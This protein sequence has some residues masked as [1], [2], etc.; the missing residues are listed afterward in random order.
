MKQSRI[1]ILLVTLCLMVMSAQAHAE[2][3]NKVFKDCV[4]C[5]DLVVIP[6]GSFDMRW[7]SNANPGHRV[8]IAKSFAIGQTEVR[9]EQWFAVMGTQP[10]NRTT[11]ANT[12]VVEVSWD[13]IQ[14]F[15][16]KLNAK[17]GKQY[18]LPSEAEWEYACRAGGHHEFCG[19]NIGSAVAWNGSDCMAP[20]CNSGD[21]VNPV[22]GITPNAF[23]LYDMSG[24]VWE[25]VEDSYHDEHHK[26]VGAPIDG[27]VWQGDGKRRVIRGGSADGGPYAV[28][29]N[30]LGGRDPKNNAYH[31][32]GFRLVRM[33]P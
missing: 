15:I 32:V 22:A 1:L 33:L 28:Y 30:K 8:T 11:F 31:D 13:E 10:A 25:W 17:T 9:R 24:N 23:G 6:A 16:Q 27:S 5:P 3:L 4:D 14:I 29:A 7:E 12:P 20:P 26:Y 2:N 19:S 21:K 18:R